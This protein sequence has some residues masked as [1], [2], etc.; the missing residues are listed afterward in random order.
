MRK[1]I[2]LVVSVLVL[3]AGCAISRPPLVELPSPEAMALTAVELPE[4]G[5]RL[6]LAPGW[7]ARNVLPDDLSWDGP[8]R[9]AGRAG[10]RLIVGDDCLQP[11]PE[12][13]EAAA[14][15]A[16]IE[17]PAIAQPLRIGDREG[18]LSGG[19]G[20]G[21]RKV[22]AFAWRDGQRTF[23]LLGSWTAPEDGVPLST[24]FYAVETIPTPIP[25]E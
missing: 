22:I 2:P 20:A 12:L 25:S 9:P 19:A 3:L 18:R 11:L 24:M 17:P 7:E 21:D 4:Y 14:M 10:L 15:M 16:G 23:L 5:L 8:P 6:F 1:R 13:V